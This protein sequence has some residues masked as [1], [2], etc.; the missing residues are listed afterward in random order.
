MNKPEIEKSIVVDAGL[1]RVGFHWHTDRFAHSIG[2]LDEGRLVPLMASIEGSASDRWPPSPPI[3]SVHT[4]Q[5]G[6]E[7]V[8][9]LLGMAGHSHWSASVQLDRERQTAKFDVACRI[10]SDDETSAAT[11]LGSQYRTMTDPVTGDAGDVRIHVGGRGACVKP[12]AD[13][14]SP[15]TE[16]C[17]SADGLLIKPV[18][19][20]DQLPCTIR[21][22]YKIT[23]QT[24]K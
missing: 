24:A 14:D 20:I 5:H 2:V 6:N 18:F 9:M 13:D 1:L 22:R 17:G 23:A 3:Q 11:T 15:Q 4:E 8:L 7:T 16:L 19:Q 10:K 12:M 21:W